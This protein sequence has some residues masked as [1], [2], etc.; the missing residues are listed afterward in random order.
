MHGMINNREC[1]ID[2]TE[3]GLYRI[4]TEAPESDGTLQ[5]DHT[6]LVL[7]TLSGGKVEGLGY[8]YADP[9]TAH[10][11]RDMLLPLVKGKNVLDRKD[12][13]HEMV[14]HIRNLGR[15]GIVSI[16]IAAVD[17]ALW[18]L[19]AKVF[20]LP[21]CRLLGQLRDEV[22]AYASGG[23]TSYTPEELGEKFGAQRDEG[24]SMFKMKIGR[25]KKQD[26]L[27]MAAARKAIGDAQ[28][29]VDANGAYFP[30]E[31]VTMASD[32]AEFN[33]SWYEEPVTSDDLDGLRF[34]RQKTGPK[35]QVSAGE[36]GY[37]L[38]YFNRMLS[39]KAVDVLQADATRCAGITGLLEVGTLC[40]ASNVPLSTH[41]APSLHLHP[42]LALKNIV[43][44]EYFE[45]HVHIEQMLFEGAASAENGVLRPDLNR[46][47]LS[48]VFKDQDAEKYKQKI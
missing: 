1:K 25:D 47:G 22:P 32:F 43:H 10:L 34:V 44:M 29:F 18:D 33:I 15:P 26:M 23:F 19:Y 9:A 12:L 28:L 17:N 41:C 24:F 45:D 36:Y 39:A 40:R 35:V 14:H 46:P 7:V 6:D 8:S 31:A 30:R 27:R 48:L 37:D 20:G 2:K 16:A 3:V 5:W 21:L 38:P 4:P 11:I 13:W 42:A